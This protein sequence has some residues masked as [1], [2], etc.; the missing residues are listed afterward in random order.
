MLV[1]I[2]QKAD[3][4]AVVDFLRADGKVSMIGL[5]GRS[6]GAVTRFCSVV[7]LVTDFCRGET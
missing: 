2:L 3:L 7:S 6:M 4:R 1:L 5:W